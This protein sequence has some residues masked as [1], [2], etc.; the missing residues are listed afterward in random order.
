MTSI[1]ATR[2][3]FVSIDN[4]NYLPIH[5]RI[6]IQHINFPLQVQVLLSFRK[7]DNS[8]SDHPAMSSH[9]STIKILEILTKIQSYYPI[10][11]ELLLSIKKWIQSRQNPDGSFTPL[12]ADKEVDYYPVDMKQSNGTQQDVDVNE[13]YYYDKEGNMTEEEIEWER[14]VEVTAETLATLLEVG[15]ENQV[16]FSRIGR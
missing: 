8:F 6:I 10:D 13:Y 4:Q 9:L 11:P 5:Q 16:G 1:F 7:T 14:R 15:V 12:S 3:V 2:V